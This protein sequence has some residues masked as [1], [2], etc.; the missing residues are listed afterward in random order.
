MRPNLRALVAEAMTSK[1]L[2]ASFRKLNAM[3]PPNSIESG[4]G[5]ILSRSWPFSDKCEI[6]VKANQ[7]VKDA[8]SRRYAEP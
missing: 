4:S 2:T 3:T 7:G 1:A 5:S 6:C 8:R